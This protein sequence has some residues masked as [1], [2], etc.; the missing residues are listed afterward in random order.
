MTAHWGVEDPATVEGSEFEKVQAFAQAARF[1]KNR[2][3]AFVSLPLPS[4]NRL[5]LQTQL[6]K[7]GVMHGSTMQSSKAG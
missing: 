5:A 7:I 1:L 2:I 6:R 3:M 4:I